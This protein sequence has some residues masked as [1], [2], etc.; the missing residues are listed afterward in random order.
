MQHATVDEIIHQAKQL[1]P[2]DRRRVVEALADT[3]EA[4]SAP[5][6][7]IFGRFAH[8]LTPVD[9]FLRRKREEVEMENRFERRGETH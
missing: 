6:A 4:Q 2:L 5:R 3:D 8:A 7:D 1:S 9:V